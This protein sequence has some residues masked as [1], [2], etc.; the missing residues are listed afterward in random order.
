[1]Q[2]FGSAADALAAHRFWDSQRI[3]VVTQDVAACDGFSDAEDREQER[4]GEDRTIGGALAHVGKRKQQFDDAYHHLP[5]VLSPAFTHVF[6]R[7][8]GALCGR[9][10]AVG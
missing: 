8:R 10:W 7:C 5:F 4:A 9:F 6:L 3:A 1:M 2:G